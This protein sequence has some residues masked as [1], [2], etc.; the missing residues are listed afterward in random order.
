ALVSRI[1]ARLVPGAPAVAAGAAAA[2]PAFPK[3]VQTA[4]ALGDGLLRLYANDAASARD[5]LSRAVAD[6]PGVV[7]S[8][9]A[10]ASAL[11]VLG[12]EVR[13]A[14]WARKAVE[15]AAPLPRV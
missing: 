9:M 11:D 5:L 14:E 12:H 4:A 15:A 7:V 13:A 2:R 3:K 6:E 8:Q 1:A 10:L